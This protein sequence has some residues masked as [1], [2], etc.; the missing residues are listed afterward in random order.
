[1]SFIPKCLPCTFCDKRSVEILINK[2]CEEDCNRLIEMYCN[3][4]PKESFQGI[5]PA[6]NRKTAEWVRAI[7][8]DNFNIIAICGERI[9]GHASL[10][11]VRT[12]DL[13]E[14]LIF[15]HQDFQDKGIG[16][17]LTEIAKLCAREY[18]FKRIWLSVSLYNSRA[19][20]VYTKTG[21]RFITPV[22]AER[23]MM[24]DLNRD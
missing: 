23:E 6:T 21:F 15:V 4:E 24:L 3:F 9:V 20:H 1:L 17:K 14:Y 2:C 18:G 11:E 5:P 19:I 13:C 10:L 8:R 7:L 22:E 16:T 12:N